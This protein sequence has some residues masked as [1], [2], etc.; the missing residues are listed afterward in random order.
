MT[1]LA[2]QNTVSVIA[3]WTTTNLESDFSGWKTQNWDLCSSGSGTKPKTLLA[4]TGSEIT[5]EAWTEF[6]SSETWIEILL[7]GDLGTQNS[8]LSQSDSETHLL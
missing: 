7:V 6:A 5:Q 1:G 2:T 4:L 8:V 3:G